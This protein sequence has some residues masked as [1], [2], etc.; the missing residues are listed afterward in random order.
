MLM[1]VF[2]R[3]TK[4]NES[5]EA[6]TFTPEVI[7]QVGVNV[8]MDRFFS[9]YEDGREMNELVIGAVDMV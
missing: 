6:L 5:Y 1:Q 2:I 8:N 3:L 4:Q 9:A 7:A